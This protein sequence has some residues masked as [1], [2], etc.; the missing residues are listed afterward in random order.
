MSFAGRR[1]SP[2]VS[3]LHL[4][5]TPEGDVDVLLGAYFAPTSPID[6]AKIL[7]HFDLFA[8]P[9]DPGTGLANADAIETLQATLCGLIAHQS[10]QGV[11][12]FGVMSTAVHH[13][14]KLFRSHAHHYADFARL[15]RNF[16]GR[17]LQIE[18]G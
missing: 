13:F 7:V 16:L 5:R 18:L 3:E 1:A 17:T 4:H 12:V 9:I 2:P 8:R 6:E 15:H 10:Q 11:L 14:D